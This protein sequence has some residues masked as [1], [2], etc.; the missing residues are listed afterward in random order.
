[1]LHPNPTMTTLARPQTSD[2][3]RL[4]GLRRWNTG[5][6]ALHLIQGLAILAL[7]SSFSLPVT[8]SFLRM[9]TATNTL[10]AVP[11]ELFRVR[12]APLIAAFLL[13]SALAHAA[14]ASPRLHARYERNLTRGIQPARWIEYSLSSSLMMVVIAMLVGIYDIAALILIFALNATMILFGWIMELHNQTTEHTNWTA[15]WFGCFAGIV[16]WI[17][18]AIYL[19]G[20]DNPPAFV[21]AIYASIFAFFNIFAVNMVLQYRRAGRWRDYLYGERVYMLLSLLAKSALAWQVFAGTLQ[22]A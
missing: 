6:S 7:A 18:V 14:L 5:L 1:N 10:I 4:R 22:P 19:I 2:A 11:N 3:P 21:Y 8:S 17:A 13:I 12:I 15:Y 16:P 9:D 20:A